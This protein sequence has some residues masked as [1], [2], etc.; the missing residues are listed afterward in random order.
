MAF[1][2]PAYKIIQELCG[3]IS[4]IFSFNYL[5]VMLGEIL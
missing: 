2:Y 5:K 1:L 3:L 4:L